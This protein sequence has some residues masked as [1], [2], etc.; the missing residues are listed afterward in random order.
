M[1]TYTPPDTCKVSNAA[2]LDYYTRPLLDFILFKSILN[3]P[4]HVNV[5]GHNNKS[6]HPCPTI[7][8]KKL[9]AICYNVLHAIIS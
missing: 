5:V 7:I 8:Y 2:E 6:K 3:L 1:N 4:Y 9:Q